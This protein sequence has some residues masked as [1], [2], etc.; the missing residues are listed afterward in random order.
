M[1]IKE[2]APIPQYNAFGAVKEDARVRVEQDTD[3]LL[4]AIKRELICEEYNKHL[5]ATDLK[6]DVH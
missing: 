6:S 2:T 1:T 3:L 5:L 4:Q